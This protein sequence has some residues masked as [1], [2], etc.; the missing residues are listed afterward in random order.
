AGAEEEKAGRFHAH[1]LPCGAGFIPPARTEVR[2][3]LARGIERVLEDLLVDGLVVGGAGAD[4][5]LV[6]QP[7]DRRVHVDHPFLAAGLYRR[8][9]LRR[10]AFE[11]LVYDS[12]GVDYA[13]R[14]G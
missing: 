4:L 8:G 13:L 3:T 11:Y 2:A 12:G 10:L 7:L 14:R 5:A 9:Y 1:G 6:E